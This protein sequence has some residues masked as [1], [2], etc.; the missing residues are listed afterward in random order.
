MEIKLNSCCY[1][2]DE[3]RSFYNHN[4]Y[5]LKNYGDWLYIYEFFKY[6]SLYI[7]EE[8]HEDENCYTVHLGYFGK[9]IYNEEVFVTILSCTNTES[10]VK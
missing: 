4:Y 2:W 7:Y 1:E 10:C 5:K 8:C 9:N 6:D 3:Q